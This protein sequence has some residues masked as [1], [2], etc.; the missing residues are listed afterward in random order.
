M[1]RLSGLDAA[2]LS[3]ES[4]SAHMHV[5]GVAIVDPTHAPDFDFGRVREHLI[6]RL[7]LIP[8]F[9]R[10]LV[11][12]PFGL[13]YP[14]WV[15]DPYFDL[16]YHLQRAA[17]PAPGTQ[18]ELAEFAAG[19]AG[20]PLDRERPLWEMYYVEGLEGGRVALISK[21]HHSAIDGLSGVDIMAHLFDLEPEPQPRLDVALAPD[22]RPD[23]VPNDAELLGYAMMSIARQPVRI[24]KTVRKMASGATKIVAR[25]RSGENK[26]ALPMTAPKLTMNGTI[27]P[28]RK[29]AFAS[30]EFAE[31]KRVKAALG[32]KVNDVVLAVTTTA[33]RNYLMDRNELPDKPLV[34]SIPTSVRTDEQ[35]GTMGNRVS[36]MFASLPVHIV[37]PLER[38]QHIHEAMMQAKDMHEEI[39][40]QTI[41]DLAELASPAMLASVKRM[42]TS[43]RLNRVGA[44]M[45]N[46]VV[47][48][49]PGPPF[50]LYLA[51]A[52]LVAMHPLGPIFNGAALN[53][54]VISYLD[55][56]D[57][58]FLACRELVP[59]LDSLAAHVP[60]AL[61][62]LSKLVDAISAPTP[63]APATTRRKSPAAGKA[64]G[65][66]PAAVVP[67]AGAKPASIAKASG[68][69]RV[70][71]RSVPKG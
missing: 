23:H 52:R 51:G 4:P 21:I 37:D 50:P 29:I 30:A 18:R 70:A 36:S 14:V 48:N 62:E 17:I 12:V 69:S 1:E 3:F 44:T 55:S 46:A 20:R 68:L 58:G 61:R 71:P 13:H 24:A 22:W 57:F 41:Q 35:A 8:P 53:L 65:V 19:V 38:L 33:L 63:S 59:D 7:P 25:V 10:R 43:L 56:I 11:H 45:H 39:G 49:V 5:L 67:A 26:A 54:T 40:A 31:V 28:H 34:V 16:D 15:E 64:V 9:R 42:V 32:V 27:T 6:E 60:D 47:S 66:K 2:F